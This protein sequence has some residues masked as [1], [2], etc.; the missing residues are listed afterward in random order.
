MKALELVKRLNKLIIEHGN[1]ELIYG[2]D[3]EGN[4]YD[5]VKFSAEV[6]TKVDEDYDFEKTEK[7]TH[8]CVN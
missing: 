8:I 7:P 1:L 5:D 4:S 6:C 3:D 2:I